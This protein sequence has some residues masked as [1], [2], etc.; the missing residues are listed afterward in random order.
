MN[1]NQNIKF[2]K[3]E[4]NCFE[5]KLNVNVDDKIINGK[6]L[7]FKTGEVAEMLGET[8]AMIRYYC[9]EFEEFL[10]L[11][12]NPG[13]HR[14]FTQKNI[15]ELKYIIKLLKEDNLTVKQV[16]E[17]LS[18]PEGKLASPIFDQQE[19]IKEMLNAISLRIDERLREIVREELQKN[20][21]PL[22]QEIVQNSINQIATTK[23]IENSFQSIKNEIIN[24]NLETKKIVEKHKK[25]TEKM[26][27]KIEDNMD[28]IN[29]LIEDSLKAK[30]KS[31]FDFFRK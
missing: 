8:P 11:K 29:K 18:S 17:F 24:E 13:E 9:K 22:F 30:R 23:D 7:T 25:N 14:I 21:V 15:E 26:F 1:D 10:S 27:E 20:L 31:I 19:K 28:K 5:E 12:H 4:K 6:P 2:S 3:E 16:H